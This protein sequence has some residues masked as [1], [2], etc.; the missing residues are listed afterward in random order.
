MRF[1]FSSTVN[2]SGDTQT[3]ERLNRASAKKTF[4]IKFVCTLI[5]IVPKEA[6]Y[7]IFTIFFA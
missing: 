6:I 7:I 4:Y 2:L 1:C 5:A 3:T